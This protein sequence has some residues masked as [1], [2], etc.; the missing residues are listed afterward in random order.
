M[1]PAALNVEPLAQVRWEHAEEA[2]RFAPMV[3]EAT[4][5]LLSQPECMAV[6]EVHVGFAVPGAVTVFLCRYTPGPPVERRS[7]LDQDEPWAWVIVGDLP[8]ACFAV[9]HITSSE[10]ALWGYI[11]MMH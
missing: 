6:E 10:E 9:A 11:T 8:P 7:Y 1:D 4:T 3:H 5:F 2:E